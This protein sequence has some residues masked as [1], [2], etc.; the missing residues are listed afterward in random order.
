MIFD[1]AGM[2]LYHSILRYYLNE[3]TLMDV[4]IHTLF[5]GE[6]NIDTYFS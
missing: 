3:K 1:P 4:K 6:Y 2:A 5:R